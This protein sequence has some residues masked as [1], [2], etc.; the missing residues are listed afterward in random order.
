MRRKDGSQ[1]RDFH[2]V[3][4]TYLHCTPHVPI[5]NNSNFYRAPNTCLALRYALFFPRLHKCND[6]MARRDRYYYP[7]FIDELRNL[8]NILVI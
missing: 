4:S 8:P 5:H 2:I 3:P 1:L 6:Q 7:H